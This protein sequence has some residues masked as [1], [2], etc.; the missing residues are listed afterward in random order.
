MTSFSNWLYANHGFIHHRFENIYGKDK[1][2]IDCWVFVEDLQSS[3]LKCLKMYENQGGYV[4]WN[5]AAVKQLVNGYNDVASHSKNSIA[6]NPQGYHHAPC[7][8][9]FDDTLSHE[10][11]NGPEKNIYQMFEQKFLF[12]GFKKTQ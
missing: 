8:T 7:S 4:D 9:Y 6:G 2:E 12:V 5:A 3:L 11:E 10:M 1:P